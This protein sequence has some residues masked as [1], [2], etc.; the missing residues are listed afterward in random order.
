MSESYYDIL[1]IPQDANEKDIKKAYKKMMLKYHPDKIPADLSD[2]EKLEYEKKSKELNEAYGIL[3]DPDK[4][5]HYDKFGKDHMNMP[6]FDMDDLMGG[7][8]GMFPGMGRRRAPQDSVPPIKVVVE[9]TLEEMY[10][11][12]SK[13]VEVERF[14]VCKPCE[15]TGFEDKT[16]HK[17]TKCKGTGRTMMTRQIG[18]GMLQQIQTEC[19]ECKGTGSDGSK[20]KKCNVCQGKKCVAEKYKFDIKIEIG[21]KDD[22]VIFIDDQGHEV[23]TKAN[24]RGKIAVVLHQIKHALFERG[25]SVDRRTVNHANLLINFKIELHEALCGVT[26]TIK[27]LDG[28]EVNIC[29]KD[30]IEDGEIRCISGDGMPYKNKMFKKGDLFVRY[31]YNYPKKLSGE[32]RE[33]IYK[34]LTGQKL[35]EIK[36]NDNTVYTSKIG[37]GENN[38]DESDDDDD[39][40]AHSH[41]PQPQCR[42]M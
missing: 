14:N 38:T 23:L 3:S 24:S 26:R 7:I 30:I 36:A 41:G 10:N 5:A 37:E 32:Q 28:R 39:E 19:P 9:V 25:V 12:T 2:A 27:H 6:D 40:H 31:T 4:R 42:Q 33:R 20:H 21:S 8:G 13:K 16:H 15:A 34:V 22:D 29:E 11:G 17:C 18:P 1:G 35:V